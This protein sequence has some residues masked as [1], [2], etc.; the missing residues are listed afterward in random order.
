MDDL[1]GSDTCAGDPSAAVEMS[2]QDYTASTEKALAL[3]AARG[4]RGQRP[5]DVR[6]ARA[7]A[8]LTALIDPSPAAASVTTAFAPGPAGPLTL[9]VY[10][11]VRDRSARNDGLRPGLVYF[12]G[13]GFVL[14]G[15]ES[16]SGFLRTLAGAT[17]RVIVA[18]D[19][20]LAPEHPFPVAVLDA[21]TAT[22]HVA[23]HAAELGIDPARLAVGGDSAGATLAAVVAQQCRARGGPEPVH[24]I[25]VTPLTLYPPQA[26]TVSRRELGEGYHLTTELLAWYA[27]CYVPDP[28][29]RT[30]PRAAPALAPDLGG[31]PAATVITGGLDPLRDEG[32]QYALALRAA[33]VDVR[34]R[35]QRGAFHLLWLATRVAPAVQA[36]VVDLIG[37][38]LGPV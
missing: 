8:A 1:T 16:D 30:D 15:P 38:R 34:V 12:H 5:A 29:D 25:L 17:Q 20:R 4:Q 27:E 24:Q 6:Q 23:A 19:Y 10:R 33:G 32:E 36:E 18:A 31:L 7:D 14:G 2:V 37:E 35:R 13:G 26:D 11:P 22:R 21:Q 3:L 28:G 9:T